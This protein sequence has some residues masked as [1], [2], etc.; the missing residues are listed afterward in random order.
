MALMVASLSLPY[1]G[2]RVYVK[3]LSDVM[4]TKA[5]W[6]KAAA[7]S[8]PTAVPAGPN[9]AVSAMGARIC[10]PAESAVAAI[11]VCL[12]RPREG[13]R[14]VR[15][16]GGVVAGGLEGGRGLATGRSGGSRCVISGRTVTCGLTMW[17]LLIVLMPAA[18]VR[19]KDV[20]RGW[21]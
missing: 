21:W 15:R 9:A 2:A 18:S 1:E 11:C 3:W 20:Q 10:T 6:S 7:M 8:P 4:S 19:A 12:Q 5:G 17:A 14:R 13:R 16:G